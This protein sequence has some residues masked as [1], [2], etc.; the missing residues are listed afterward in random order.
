MEV[1]QAHIEEM[2]RS[3]L[4]EKL[5]N[6]VFSEQAYEKKIIPGGVI[7]IALPSVKVR[8]ED[9][10]DT[11]NRKDQVYTRDVLTLSE[12]KRLGCGIMEMKETTFPWKL[13]YDEVDY[14]IAGE[15][16]VIVGKEMVQASAGEM[17]FIP[18][19]S[20]IQFSVRDYARFLYVT[21]PADWAAQ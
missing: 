21:Y 7:S 16:E 5:E 9:R 17:I 10:L 20:E 19:G 14:V 12:S 6:Y 1:N 3:I 18:K 11:G 8:E 2:I 13:G 15:L 4:K